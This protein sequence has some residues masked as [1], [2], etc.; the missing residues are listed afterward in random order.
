MT[1]AKPCL[2]GCTDMIGPLC[3]GVDHTWE[4]PNHSRFAN[5][6]CSPECPTIRQS[7]MPK[8]S[9]GCP[10]AAPKASEAPVEGYQPGRTKL[11]NLQPAPAPE[12][13]QGS[14]DNSVFTAAQA[15]YLSM[16]R[17]RDALRADLAAAQVE[18]K[19]LK[20]EKEAFREAHAE[21]ARAL[22]D[23]REEIAKLRK[24]VSEAMHEADAEKARA[25]RAEERVK[26]LEDQDLQV[27]ETDDTSIDLIGFWRNAR[28]RA[29]AIL[30]ARARKEGG[31]R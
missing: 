20:F 15:A 31:S 1:E 10:N 29:R 3:V 23:A 26:E 27:L 7:G 6:K 21:K 14:A 22:A 16:E 24:F 19:S 13:K 12:P 25:D 5:P 30:A 17:E 2:P 28:A 4:C 11:G 18:I 9:P 8:H